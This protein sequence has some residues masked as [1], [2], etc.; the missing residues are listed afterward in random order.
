MP[1]VAVVSECPHK[2]RESQAH[3]ALSH[4]NSRLVTLVLTGWLDGEDGE[5]GTQCRSILHAWHSLE[6]VGDSVQLEP[7]LAD[8]VHREDA[9]PKA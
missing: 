1:K 4:R 2:Q 7:C 6:A 3:K 8:H 5:T 9:P